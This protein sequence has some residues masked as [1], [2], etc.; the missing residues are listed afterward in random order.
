M[1]GTPPGVASE[2]EALDLRQG[3]SEQLLER[4]DVLRY[5]ALGFLHVFLKVQGPPQL[6]VS[7]VGGIVSF[8][9]WPLTAR[10]A[11][12]A[13]RSMSRQIPAST[14]SVSNCISSGV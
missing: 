9:I 14:P 6:R 3:V 2:V 1:A 12:I 7:S 8:T 13:Q 4:L 10:D 5:P 11:A